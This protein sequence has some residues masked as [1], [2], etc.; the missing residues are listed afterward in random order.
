[1]NRK[2]RQPHRKARY[3]TWTSLVFILSAASSA[4]APPPGA[5][6]PQVVTQVAQAQTDPGPRR[7]PVQDVSTA[8]AQRLDRML[9]DS[10]ATPAR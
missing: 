7:Q 3:I 2:P 1:M 5:V 10:K 6:P 4:A 8:L 9:A